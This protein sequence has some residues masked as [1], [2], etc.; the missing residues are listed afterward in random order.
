V[1]ELNESGD[2]EFLGTIFILLDVVYICHSVICFGSIGYDVWKASR[3]K[4]TEGNEVVIRPSVVVPIS[5]GTTMP[6]RRSLSQTKGKSVRT[7]KVE[8]IQKNHEAHRNNRKKKLEKRQSERRNSVNARLAARQ[9]AKQNHA[10]ETSTESQTVKQAMCTTPK[11]NI[12]GD[13]C[14][15]IDPASGH[16]Y[17]L[18]NSTGMSQWT[19]PDSIPLSNK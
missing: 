8:E 15:L 5:S 2:N 3:K 16:L 1:N 18:D 11:G 17:Y 4:I 13:W 7:L 19:W 6:N 10:T 9:K 12:G 14:E